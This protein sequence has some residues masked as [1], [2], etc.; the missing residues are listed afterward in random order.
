M[1]LQNS[2]PKISVCI[3][4][5]NGSKFLR[6]A[7]ESVLT[8]DYQDYELVIVDN[9]SDDDSGELIGNLKKEYNGV[10]R[11]YR[12]ERNI[13]MAG[14]LNKCLEY[15]R[16][17]YI[18]YLCADD[19][20]LPG[21]LEQMANRLDMNKSA[22]LVTSARQ[23]VDEHGKELAIERYACHDLIVQGS[24]AVTRCLYGRN[25]IG[26]PSAVMFR[27]NVVA[28]V[29]REDMPQLLDLD[30]WFQLLEYGNLLYI[31]ESLCAVRRHASQMS[32]ANFK[33]GLVVENHA[34]LYDLYSLKL[35]VKPTLFHIVQF[36]F[37]MSYRVWISRE[38]I[39]DGYMREI[40]GKYSSRLMYKLMPIAL[41]CLDFWRGICCL[42]R[43]LLP[44]GKSM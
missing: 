9:C 1:V 17:T 28:G 41:F 27:R 18:K 16:G 12:N 21:C 37:L 5:Y 40:L 8:Q 35:Y 24:Q 38:Y 31:N 34:K 30:M 42:W 36:K 6:Q 25:Y 26:E 39:S 2:M 14:N 23:L 32:L 3:P 44:N 4:T 11:S 7:V 10:I 13:G 29:F 22:V 20:L 33:A 15:A 43:R 19:F